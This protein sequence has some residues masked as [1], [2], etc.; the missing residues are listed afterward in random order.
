RVLV[1]MP[2]TLRQYTADHRYLLE[3][4]ARQAGF[5]APVAIDL[6]EFYDPLLKSSRK[7]ELLPIDGVLVRDWDPDIRREGPGLSFGLR[8]Y[9]LWVFRAAFVRGGYDNQA[10]CR[11]LSFVAVDRRD[12][13]GFYRLAQKAR[14]H[15]EPPSKPP[16]LPAEQIDVLW[17]NPIGYL[18]PANL[19]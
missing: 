6:D 15:A 7:G 10:L 2:H 18:E 5:T 16:V 4:V 3:V 1:G 12:Y 9:P 8:L 17:K 11:G 19:K 13:R 14:R